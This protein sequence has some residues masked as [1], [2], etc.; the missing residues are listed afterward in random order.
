MGVV[1]YSMCSVGERYKNSA[2]GHLMVERWGGHSYFTL[3]TSSH[4]LPTVGPATQLA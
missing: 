2:Q 3:A 1:L 4:V